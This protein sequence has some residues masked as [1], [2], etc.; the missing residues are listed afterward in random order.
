MQGFGRQEGLDVNDSS[1]VKENMDM[2]RIVE[3]ID[4]VTEVLPEMPSDN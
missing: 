2:Q 1:D 3:V 4:Q